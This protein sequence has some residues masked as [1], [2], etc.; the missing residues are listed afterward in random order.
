M[1]VDYTVKSGP[2]RV[3]DVL[4]EGCV[5]NDG[6]G[7]AGHEAGMAGDQTFVGDGV[8][9]PGGPRDERDEQEGE[10]FGYPGGSLGT[11]GFN[12]WSDTELVIR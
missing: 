5:P 4:G 2:Q 7:N 10:N 9:G 12:H 3:R 11:H 6:G 1:H 8:A